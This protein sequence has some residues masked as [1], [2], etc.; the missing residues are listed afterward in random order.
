MPSRAAK[1]TEEGSGALP[2]PSSFPLCRETFV[3]ATLWPPRPFP[4]FAVGGGEA[5]LSY[6]SRTAPYQRDA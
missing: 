3:L 6:A 5:G 4:R 1:L 2:N